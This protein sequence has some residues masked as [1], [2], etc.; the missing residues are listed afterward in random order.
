M[1]QT[2]TKCLRYFVVVTVLLITAACRNDEPEPWP[3][4]GGNALKV[5]ETQVDVGFRGRYCTL[6]IDGLSEDDSIVSVS[7]STEWVVYEE[8]FGNNLLLYIQPNET[9]RRRE[10]TISILSALGRSSTVS[11]LQHSAA[12]DDDNALEQDTLS[13]VARVGYGYHLLYDYTDIKSVSD[14]PVFDYQALV[15]AERDY[16]TIVGQ[17][18]NNRIDYKYYT[19]YSIYEMASRLA[20]EQTNTASFLGLSKK[21]SRYTSVSNYDA[22]QECYGYAK[23]TK[24]VAS[25]FIDMGKVDELLRQPSRYKIFTKDFAGWVA[26][27]EANPSDASAVAAFVSKYGSHVIIYADLGGR[28]DYEVNFIKNE[29]NREEMERYMKTVMGREK[30]NK[31]TESVSKSVQK[32]GNV[33]AETFGGNPAIGNALKHAVVT[34]DVT[35]EQLDPAAVADWAATIDLAQPKYLTMANCR[36]IPIWQLLASPAAQNAVRSHILDL[37]EGLTVQ[38]KEEL[39]LNNYIAISGLQKMV[40]FSSAESLVKIAYNQVI[41]KFEICNEYVPELRGD[42]RVTIIYP[43]YNGLTNIRHGIF[44]GDGENTPSEISFDDKG[45][46]YVQPLE[47]CSAGQVLDTLYYIDGALY[48]TDFGIETR[49]RQLRVEYEWL[50]INGHA[51]LYPIV[52]IG[53][54][55]WTRKPLTDLMGF[56]KYYDGEWTYK[57]HVVGGVLYADVYCP[58]D[59]IFNMSADFGIDEGLWFVPSVNDLNALYSYIGRNPKALFAGQQTG[60]EA[61]FDG[62]LATY[63]FLEHKQTGNVPR[64]LYKG[65]AVFIPFKNERTDYENGGSALVLM[66]DYSLTQVKLDIKNVDN[67]YAVRPFRNSLFRHKNLNDN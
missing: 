66:P 57:E 33:H 60:F 56:G 46:I 10:A 43:I 40:D 19:S 50:K 54:G 1:K 32:A 47:G 9:M 49:S 39:G 41:P 3:G 18:S 67:R 22:Q 17:E 64:F 48:G 23:F 14:D 13:R 28:L 62:C 12:E 31:V 37:A 30:E 61:T 58:K 59:P 52:K 2:I 11:V 25:R 29:V 27:L 65:Q 5:S 45:G 16:G 36:L 7:P 53:H 55:M 4:Y 6:S 8:A 26:R 24:V 63:D 44:I 20:K 35:H 21:V 42:R 51:S 38:K 15:A 34:Y